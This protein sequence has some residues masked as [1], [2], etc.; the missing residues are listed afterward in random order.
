M[1]TVEKSPTR[2]EV[3]ESIIEAVHNVA[4]SVRDG[5]PLPDKFDDSTRL[6]GRS[7]LFDS[8]G[9]VS[10]VVEVEQLLESQFEAVIVLADDRA[11]S[12][13][14]SPFLTIGSLADYALHLIDEEQK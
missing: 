11:M 13:E 8:M 9:L 7:G 14:R 10:L 2:D 12:Q 5:R 4:A 6:M 3:V 1:H